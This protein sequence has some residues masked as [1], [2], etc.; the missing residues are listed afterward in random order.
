[1]HQS[2]DRVILLS[3][4]G[5]TVKNPPR[6][7]LRGFSDFVNVGSQLRRQANIHRVKN[8]NTSA[9]G[10]TAPLASLNNNNCTGGD[11]ACRSV[12]SGVSA[13]DHN[14]T[15]NASSACISLEAAE[16]G[17]IDCTQGSVQKKLNF[18][19]GRIEKD[20]NH[21]QAVSAGIFT[22]RTVNDLAGLA[23]TLAN[24][25]P[26]QCIT[27]GVCASD[28]PQ[29]L[30]TADAL[31]ALE[32][33][34]D[35]I[36]RTLDHLHWP[37]TGFGMLDHDA[38]PGHPDLNADEFWAALLL[39][40]PELG[41]V[42]RVV[43]ASTSSNIYSS[44]GGELLRGEVGHHTYLQI[45]GDVAAFAAWLHT[46]LWVN[47]QAFFKLAS[48]NKTT[49]V[50]AVLERGLVDRTTFSPERIIYEAGAICGKGIEQRRQRPRVIAG[51]VLNI[52]DLPP[53]TAAEQKQADANRS[54]AKA[55]AK[56]DQ[57]EAA[58]GNVVAAQGV[59]PTQARSIARQ[60]I[61]MAERGELTPDHPIELES[62]ETVLA[63]DLDESHVGKQCRD[64]QEPDYN[65]GR[66]CAKIY[67]ADDDQIWI[68]SFAHGGAK[69]K[70]QNITAEYLLSLPATWGN[71]PEHEQKQRFKH[72]YRLVIANL[73]EADVQL[74][75]ESCG[76]TWK[77]ADRVEAFRIAHEIIDRYQQQYGTDSLLSLNG[78]IIW[79]ALK[80]HKATYDYLR[81]KKK[82]GDRLRF[83]DLLQVIEFDREELPID[84][85][86]VWFELE[87]GFKSETVKEFPE[88][89]LQLA[90]ERSYHPVREHL[91]GCNRRY[92]DA[93]KNGILDKVAPIALGRNEAIYKTMMRKFLIGAAARPMQPGCKLDTVLILQGPQGYLKSTFFKTL[94]NNWF[95]DSLGDA[96]GSKDEQLK[97]HRCWMAEWAELETVF[98]KKDVAATKAFLSCS[99]DNVRPPYGRSVVSM[100]R[101]GVLCGTTNEDG[102][103]A[104]ATGARRFWI[105]GIDQI[106]DIEWL[107]YNRDEIWAAAYQALEAGESWWLDR[108]EDDQAAEIAKSYQST[109]PWDSLVMTYAEKY[110]CVTTAEVLELGC[111]I[112]PDRLDKKSEMRVSTILKQNGWARKKARKDG[113]S[114][115]VW[116]P[117][118]KATVNAVA[119]NAP[120]VDFAETETEATAQPPIAGT[121]TEAIEIE[122]EFT[123][124]DDD[125]PTDETDF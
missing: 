73:P 23:D 120:I 106:I 115:W 79:A 1:M 25:L 96:I 90:R 113:V 117:T 104:D 72:T 45:T 77:K 66:F 21:F 7:K 84:G 118:A 122:Y 20:A 87:H 119:F 125:T 3:G 60:A 98:R 61:A 38:E 39:S 33:P 18:V 46:R 86:R 95:D 5:H 14:S 75:A 102:F 19:D 50:S 24:L 83:N 74:F 124:D 65:G 123:I 30:V 31:A 44:P 116:C 52:A 101:S 92:P 64:P 108:D 103:L 80:R 69:Y 26:N 59:S 10:V 99:V 28:D 68:N 91:E 42:G 8:M 34:E 55:K 2:P 109:D 85:M 53:I 121:E 41:K 36:A 4:Y 70:V 48:P 35:T 67:Q 76:R 22:N 114:K 105:I 54:K 15:S 71:L 78:S 58:V 97:L 17:V 111:K 6:C 110:D 27:L 56:A 94:A 32:N 49:G 47:N 81:L 13:Q 16:I 63:G 43:V 51:D 93:L 62:G 89:A 9:S 100:K 57:L 40:A 12:P 82:F 112:T 29:T 37:G 107:T 11:R 88:V